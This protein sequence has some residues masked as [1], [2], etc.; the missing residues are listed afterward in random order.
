MC[1]SGSF[2]AFFYLNTS[3]VVLGVRFKLRPNALKHIWAVQRVAC[4]FWTFLW[5]VK[6]RLLSLLKFVFRMHG[7]ITAFSIWQFVLNLGRPTNTALNS[8][9]S[10]VQ[11]SWHP[12]AFLTP[13]QELVQQ[14]SVINTIDEG[15]FRLS[16]KY[17]HSLFLKMLTTQK[18]CMN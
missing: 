14:N 2:Y 12:R 17:P 6:H 10:T 5:L 11:R 15:R 9:P 4:N 13:P 16:Q 7:L 18:N 8:A 3:L 1:Y